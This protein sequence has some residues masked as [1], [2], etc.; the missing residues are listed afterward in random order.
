VGVGSTSSPMH[1]KGMIFMD[2][3]GYGRAF[4]EP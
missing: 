3:I 1:G 4:V 2:D